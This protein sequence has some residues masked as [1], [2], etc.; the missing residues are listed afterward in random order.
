MYKDKNYVLNDLIVNKFGKAFAL[1]NKYNN[2][3]IIIS[4]FGGASLASSTGWGYGSKISDLK[5][6][7]EQLK[8]IFNAIYSLDYIS[9]F[10]Y[11]QVSDVEQETNGLFYEDRTLKVN[12][13]FLIEIIGGNKK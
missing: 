10:C 9:G 3:P 7:I 1:N 12:I 4:E 2:Q 8:N 5:K 6:Y 13:N 11:T